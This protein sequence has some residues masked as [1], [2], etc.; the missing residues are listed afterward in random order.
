LIFGLLALL[1]KIYLAFPPFIMSLYV[2]LF[3]SPK[4]GLI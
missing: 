1:T 4:R 3:V 2:F